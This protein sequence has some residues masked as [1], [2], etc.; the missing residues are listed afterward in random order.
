MEI[1]NVDFILGIGAAVGIGV[2]AWLLWRTRALGAAVESSRLFE[3]EEVSYPKNLDD[4][5]RNIETPLSPKHYPIVAAA[6]P[7]R[8]RRAKPTAKKT[9]KK[10]A[11]KTAKTSRRIR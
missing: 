10:T 5:M 6:K 1:L 11:K 9:V 7:S 2:L 8:I 4:P 3:S